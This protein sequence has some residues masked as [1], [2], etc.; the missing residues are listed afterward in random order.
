M[1][2][3]LPEKVRGTNLRDIKSEGDTYPAWSTPLCVCVCEKERETTAACVQTHE[4]HHGVCHATLFPFRAWT[5]GKTK[6]IIN[7]LY[8]YFKRWSSQLWQGPLHFWHRLWCSANHNALISWLIRADCACRKE[9][10]CRKRRVWEAGHRGP[11][12][13]Y[14]IW[15]II[16]FFKH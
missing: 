13:I 11:T 2:A 4:L 9:G 12:I 1:W 7:C 14:R 6:D 3:H 5:D 8:I 15:K 16:Y 10:L